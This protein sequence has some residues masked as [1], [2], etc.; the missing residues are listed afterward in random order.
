[1]MYYNQ[2]YFSKSR[3]VSFSITVKKPPWQKQLKGDKVNSG[4][5]SKVQSTTEGKQ[6][7]LK[8]LLTLQPVRKQREKS[9]HRC[10]APFSIL[11]STGSQPGKVVTYN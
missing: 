2:N 5:P 8:W 9:T 7:S 6:G 11:H 4:S 3:L 10:S 1:M